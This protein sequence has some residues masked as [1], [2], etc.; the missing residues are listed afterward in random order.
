M[1][2]VWQGFQWGTAHPSLL[3]HLLKF[4]FLPMYNEGVSQC[5]L[6]VEFC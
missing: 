5:G 6:I 2:K 4:N 1:Q 3:S